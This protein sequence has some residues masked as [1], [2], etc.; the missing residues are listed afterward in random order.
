MRDSNKGIDRREFTAGAA[1]TGLACI[2]PGMK[3]SPEN[4]PTAVWICRTKD[5]GF[6]MYEATICNSGQIQM[7]V[8]Q[9]GE[10]LGSCSAP[11]APGCWHTSPNAKPDLELPGLV[12][13]FRHPDLSDEHWNHLKGQLVSGSAPLELVN[14]LSVQ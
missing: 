12:P 3:P 13:L 7:W 11:A 14:I 8:G 1:V 2:L 6:G 4:T 5:Y 9:L 10:P